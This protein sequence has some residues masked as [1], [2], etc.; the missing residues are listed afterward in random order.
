M[1]TLMLLAP[2]L[3][4][5]LMP[6]PTLLAWEGAFEGHDSEHWIDRLAKGDL[7]IRRKAAWALWSLAPRTESAVTALAR[8]H[9][10]DDAYVRDTCAKSLIRLESAAGAA[11]P[12]LADQLASEREE[13]RRLAMRTIFWLGKLAST[14]VPQLTTALG[15]KDP[16]I[17]ANAAAGLAHAGPAA[18]PAEPALSK[19]LDHG[20]PET[21]KWAARA[22]VAIDPLSAFRHKRREVR[23][24]VVIIHVDTDSP[25]ELPVFESLLGAFD[26]EDAQVRSLAAQAIGNAFLFGVRTPA[27]MYE[28]K[29][30][31][32]ARLC[33]SIEKDRAPVMRRLS[34]YALG[35]VARHN[36]GAFAKEALPVLLGAAKD[37]SPEVRCAAFKA[38]LLL[39]VRARA[40]VPL[41]LR[42][43][44]DT[45]DRV[46]AIATMTLGG[47]A[48]PTEE[49]INALVEA[50]ESWDPSARRFA[51]L[52]LSMF[53]AA[54]EPAVPALLSCLD[55][56][57]DYLTRSRVA[58]ALA[59]IGPGA[60][61]AE[62]PLTAI[63]LS[64]KP[65][66][67]EIA[68]ALCRLG[69]PHTGSALQRLLDVGMSNVGGAARVYIGQLGAIAKPVVPALIRFV[70]GDDPD[71]RR[72]A[73]YV[74]GDLGPWASDAI[75][76]LEKA[77]K[78]GGEV[79]VAAEQALRKIRGQ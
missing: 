21:A 72:D 5:F 46:R 44:G 6:T 28:V 13:V 56:H 59:K 7:L 33:Q 22:L 52:S 73:A 43:M 36:D 45:N 23:L 37:V 31:V 25:H 42:A 57:D 3:L 50:L 74:L 64:D 16:I 17:S 32:L 11:M 39:G 10:D 8:A 1:R 47:V 4:I 71:R 79:C 76:A 63:Y 78:A 27:W 68:F 62:K 40:A 30:R 34:T 53:G 67:I 20:D 19:L 55:A 26:D 48:A 66:P 69:S 54:A 41:L 77:V 18:K 65:C 24:R 12:I 9:A 75:P 61:A 35:W 60:K 49:V 14:I 29:P 70:E 38:F 51:A 15:S 2:A 58:L